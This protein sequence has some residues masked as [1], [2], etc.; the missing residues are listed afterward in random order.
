MDPATILADLLAAETAAQNAIA[1][2]DQIKASQDAATQAQISA[3]VIATGAAF[4]KARQ[5]LDATVA[6]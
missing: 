1:A 3:Q 6:G 4:D 5:A 2:W